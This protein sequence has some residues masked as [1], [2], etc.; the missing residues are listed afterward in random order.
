MPYWKE[1]FFLFP[2]KS[3]GETEIDLLEQRKLN[4]V[5]YQKN[6]ILIRIC[7]TKK[8]TF[9]TLTRWDLNI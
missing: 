6:M 9:S 4:E 2:G 8:M 1:H 5:H 7:K 3:V